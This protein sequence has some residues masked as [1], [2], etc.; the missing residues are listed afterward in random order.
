LLDTDE[1]GVAGL[2]LVDD[3]TLGEADREIEDGIHGGSV[4]KPMSA[5]AAG[6]RAPK[7]LAAGAVLDREAEAAGEA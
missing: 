7:A 4:A 6:V 1:A 2:A 5:F 3:R